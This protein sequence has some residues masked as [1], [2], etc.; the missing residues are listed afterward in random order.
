MLRCWWSYWV[1]LILL[2][3]VVVCYRWLV[4]VLMLLVL[5]V[6][7]FIDCFVIW[8]VLVRLWCWSFMLVCCGCLCW[9]LVIYWCCVML[10]FWRFNG[11]LLCLVCVVFMRCLVGILIVWVKFW[12]NFC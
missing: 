11:G 4:V 1:W 12:C 6:I 10:R 2:F 3:C 7:F 5:N 9:M 8:C